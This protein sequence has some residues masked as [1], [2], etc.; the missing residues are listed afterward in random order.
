[1]SNPSFHQ[2]ARNRGSQDFLT[3]SIGQKGDAV[4]SMCRTDEIDQVTLV[5]TICRPGLHRMRWRIRSN[6]AA[7]HPAMWASTTRDLRLHPLDQRTPL[8]LE[9]FARLICQGNSGA[10]THLQFRDIEYPLK[11][12]AGSIRF[13]LLPRAPHGAPIVVRP[14]SR[15][16]Q[17]H[18]GPVGGVNRVVIEE[19]PNLLNVELLTSQIVQLD[20]TLYQL[21]I[22]TPVVIA[23]PDATGAFQ[24]NKCATLCFAPVPPEVAPA[25]F[26]SLRRQHGCAEAFRFLLVLG[27]CEEKLRADVAI[28]PP[29]PSS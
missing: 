24:V 21:S 5:C 23:S 15:R 20:Q 26:G 4:G 8:G 11:R 9:T 16:R 1:M 25:I 10:S 6:A 2:S 18:R 13:P 27:G 14:Q 22:P 28:S 12:L 29:R 17:T 3:S 19:M 7:C